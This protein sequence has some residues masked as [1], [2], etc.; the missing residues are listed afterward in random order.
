MIPMAT[1]FTRLSV[2]AGQRQLDASVPASRPVGEFL[3]LIP[4]ML[5]LEATTPP[6][7]WA[8]STP[9]HGLIPLE[10]SLDDLGVLD[11]DILYLSPATGTA[12]SPMV[13]D[14]LGTVGELVET[15][16]APWLD[17]HR[18]RVIANLLGLVLV[19]VAAAGYQV[20]PAPVSTLVLLAVA[21]L[22]AGLAGLR[23]TRGGIVADWGAPLIGALAL[24][25]LDL[26]LPVRLMAAAAGASAGLALVSGV[27]RRPELVVLGA[28]AAVLSAVA[29]AVLNADVSPAMVAGW[30]GP[31]LVI[32]L[33]VLPQ[34]ALS[35]SGLVALVQRGEVGD[36]VAR[37]ELTRRLGAAT[38]RVDGT[39]M[40]V[41]IAGAVAC[42]TLVWSADPAQV[43]LGL[44]IG[45]LFAM[46]SRG[47]S[48]ARL[49]G[50]TVAAPVVAL[51]ALAYWLPVWTDQL[52]PAAVAPVQVVSVLL[53]LVVVA[54]VGFTRL[55]ELN[56]ARMT[57]LLDV[58]DTVATIAF[59]PLLLFALHVF[60]ALL[61]AL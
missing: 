10:R 34:L 20:T 2:V 51:A 41:G 44:L 48:S 40:A 26:P 52:V 55:R 15:R 25:R 35:S 42:L 49:V 36:E 30:A 47:F 58:V 24:L 33:G 29:G 18:D 53:V 14:V 38:A 50:F 7:E 43:A 27:R 3:T 16:A 21:A 46:R 23:L 59:I 13:E 4:S 6:T 22:C 17:E 32:A 37:A 57:R 31:V 11:G 56:A 39:V 19:L 12:E 54:L 5:S 60:T 8:L 28:A 9:R 45:L 61:R 1:R